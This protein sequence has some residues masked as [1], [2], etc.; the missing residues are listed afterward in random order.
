MSCL[1]C[2][3]HAFKVLCL[4]FCMY[5]N[6]LVLAAPPPLCLSRKFTDKQHGK[7]QLHSPYR[8]PSPLTVCCH[9]RSRAKT[10]RPQSSAGR[11][12]PPSTRYST[13]AALGCAARADAHRSLT[14]AHQGR[15]DGPQGKVWQ[16]PHTRGGAGGLTE[17]F[18]DICSVRCCVVRVHAMLPLTHAPS[19]LA[20]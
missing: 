3:S 11:R 7:Q 15:G 5:T 13:C 14:G 4:V 9:A 6:N 12:L 16:E 1:A 10:T 17:G 2:P 8:T 18:T 19:S 20:A